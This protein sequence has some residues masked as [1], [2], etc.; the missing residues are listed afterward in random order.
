M[1]EGAECLRHTKIAVYGGINQL[2]VN[3]KSCSH[4]SSPQHHCKKPHTAI[5]PSSHVAD[6][7]FFV[8]LF[9]QIRSFKIN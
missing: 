8:S 1:A 3:Q 4:V 5:K 2:A 6:V 7:T 9:L